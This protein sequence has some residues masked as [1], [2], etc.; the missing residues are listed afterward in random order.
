MVG[1]LL[2]S[3]IFGI[4]VTIC[5][6]LLAMLFSRAVRNPAWAN[7]IL[8]ASSGIVALLLLARI[9][10]EQYMVG[11]SFFSPILGLAVVALAAPPFRHRRLLRRS[12]GAIVSAVGL[13]SLAG[14]VMTVVLAWGLG[15]SEQAILSAAPKQATSPVALDVAMLSGG[16]GELAAV[17]AVLTGI[18]G[19]T[20]GPGLLRLLRFDDARHRGLAM[21]VSAHAIGTSRINATEPVSGAFAVVGMVLAALFVTVLVPVVFAVV[22]L[23]TGP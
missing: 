2:E 21:G 19:A 7:P 3:P 15:G 10:Y 9:D 13:G 18:L 23:F 4:A 1:E 6:F 5:G 20:A 11:G 12:S 14:V 22:T 8:W 17:L 16:S